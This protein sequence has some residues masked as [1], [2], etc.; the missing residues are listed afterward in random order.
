VTG[1][2]GFVVDPDA[3]REALESGEPVELRVIED[4][5]P[6]TGAARRGRPRSSEAH[7]AILQAVLDLLAEVGYD[8]VSMEA[9]AQRAGVSKATVYRRWTSKTALVLDLLES[10]AATHA[11]PDT[12]SVRGDL[13]QMVDRVVLALV[14]AQYGAILTALASELPRNPE[15]AETFRT[16]FLAARRAAMLAV[17]Q[18]G[19][20]RGEL[21]ADADLEVVMDLLVGPLYYRVLVS[22]MPLSS[23]YAAEIVDHVLQG[24]SSQQGP[25]AG[26]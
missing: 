11:P 25:D 14:H 22:G 10:I 9:V 15:M 8:A 4:G 3:V 2:V 20:A 19:L 23:A 13:H 6:A 24:V 16:H 26:R 18:R 17:L 7:L 1:S 5:E 21:R 12:G